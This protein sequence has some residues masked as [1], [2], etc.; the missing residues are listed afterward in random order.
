MKFLFIAAFLF[1]SIA[2]IK[3]QEKPVPDTLIVK[4]IV[5]EKVEIETDVSESQWRHLLEINLVP[6]IKKAA[7]KMKAGNYKISVRFLKEKDG[8]ITDVRALNNPGYG[9]AEGAVKVIRNWPAGAGPKWVSSDSYRNN[10][11]SYHT[12]LITFQIQ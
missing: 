4:G 10:A 3:G 7:K 9:L 12:Q 2:E 1:F 11:R 6:V 5:F 8:S